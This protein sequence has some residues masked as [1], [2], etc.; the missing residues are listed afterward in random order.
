MDES[1]GI[2][3]YKRNYPNV[4]AF[5]RAHRMDLYFYSNPNGYLPYKQMILDT[6]DAFFSIS[7]DGINYLKNEI[8]L[9]LSYNV[10]LSYLGT[11]KHMKPNQIVISQ[12]LNRVIS[13]SNIYPNK[14]VHLIA[15]GLSRLENVITWDHYGEFM[16]ST[17]DKYK[18]KHDQLIKKTRQTHVCN[19]K[20]RF[21]N[22][23][24]MEILFL[25]HMMFLLT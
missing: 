15:D 25:S 14:R 12:D 2:S 5:T 6:L 19:M 8:N 18:D 4:K 21:S 24:L 3:L 22:A 17:S 13:C 11:K 7:K 10:K 1:I 9:S 20:G 23:E 16:D